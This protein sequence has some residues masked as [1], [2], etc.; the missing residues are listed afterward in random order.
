MT[1]RIALLE[2]S[3]LAPSHGSDITL[4]SF[5]L[6]FVIIALVLTVALTFL[7]HCSSSTSSHSPTPRFDVICKTTSSWLPTTMTGLFHVIQPMREYDGVVGTPLAPALSDSQSSKKMP[8]TCRC[9]PPPPRKHTIALS[10][11]DSWESLRATVD[12]H[13]RHIHYGM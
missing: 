7:S 2:T 10:T 11:G 8:I 5:H 13:L 3:V 1:A 12:D 4:P 6:S 9:L